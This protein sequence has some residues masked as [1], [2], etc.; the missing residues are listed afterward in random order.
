MPA[1]ELIRLLRKERHSV[2]P[3]LTEG[4]SHFVTPMSLAALAESPVYTSLWDLKDE[5]EMGHIQLSRAADLVLVAPATADLIAR[6]A[7]GEANDLATTLLLATDKPVVI[8][9]AMNVRMWQHAATQRN[10]AQLRADRITVL[11]PTKAQWPAANMG[12]GRLPEPA[13]IYEQIRPMLG[14]A[15]PVDSA[16][17]AAGRQAH[18]RHCRTDAGADRPGSRDRQPFVWQAGLC[19]RRR[20]R[21][22]RCAGD[23]GRRAGIF[24]D[25]RWRRAD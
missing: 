1:A 25:A 17:P 5:A 14:P 21:P 12:P 6:M 3:V 16:E 7:A 10:I 24:A 11:S 9:P 22:G 4:G 23:A 13:D 15:A 18:P 8:A 20:R 19:Y 2:T